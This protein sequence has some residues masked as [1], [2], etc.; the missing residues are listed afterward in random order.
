[1]SPHGVWT[2][3]CLLHSWTIVDQDEHVRRLAGGYCATA[4]R[5]AP[6]PPIGLYSRLSLSRPSQKTNSA[7]GCLCW[8]QRPINLRHLQ[9]TY[10][11]SNVALHWCELTLP[12]IVFFNKHIYRCDIGYGCSFYHLDLHVMMSWSSLKCIEQIGIIPSNY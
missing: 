9:I 5:G 11:S 8:S 6:R 3:S 1:M 12:D 2:P 7:L 4:A 10:P